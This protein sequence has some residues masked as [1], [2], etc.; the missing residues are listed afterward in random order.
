VLHASPAQRS[1]IQY[2]HGRTLDGYVTTVANVLQ[3]TAD[4]VARR[5]NWGPE[6][7]TKEITRIL[8]QEDRKLVLDKLRDE[9]SN[10]Y[11]PTLA[12]NCQQLMKYALP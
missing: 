8:A 11:F 5:Y 10:Q 4:N 9:Y 3:R 6:G 1:L 7:T 2:G 12:K